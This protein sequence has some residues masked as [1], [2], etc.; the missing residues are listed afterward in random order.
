VTGRA[1]GASSRHLP[2]CHPWWS[3]DVKEPDERTYNMC[4]RCKNLTVI[5]ATNSRRIGALTIAVN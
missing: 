5:T 2:G 1:D 3:L 4:N